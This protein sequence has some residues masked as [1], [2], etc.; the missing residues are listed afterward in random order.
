MDTAS[1]SFDPVRARHS[2]GRAFSVINRDAPA[3]WLCEARNVSAVSRRAH[4]A[5]MRPDAWWSDLG[6]R[7]LSAR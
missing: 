6:D 7:T 3:V 5:A 4:V 2:S 1:Q